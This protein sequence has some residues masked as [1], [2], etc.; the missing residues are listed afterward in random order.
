MMEESFAHGASSLHRRDARVKIIAA[1]CFIAVVAVADDFQ[2]TVAALIRSLLL[3]MLAKLPPLSVL[4]RLAA[5]NT[6]TLFL[7]LTLP[8]TYGGAELVQAGPIWISMPGV[9]LA[10]LITLK[11]NIIVLSLITMLSTSPVAS[12][13]HALEALKF[14]RRLTFLL[15]FSYRYVFVIYQEYLKLRRA[16]QLRSFIPRTSIHTYRT[17]GYLFGMT[18][19]RSWNRSQR[20]YQ[21]MQLRGFNGILIPLD[22]SAISTKDIVFLGTMI[23]ISLALLVSQ[24]IQ[25]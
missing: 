11:T 25:F 8:F 6:F 9:R 7:W 15:L 16:A 20:V 14:P 24:F 17:F 1:F 12:L 13:G 21:A 18:L 4:K 2:T 23:T 10:A 3:L 22:Q 19:V 5:A